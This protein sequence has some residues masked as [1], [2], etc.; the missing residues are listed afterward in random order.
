MNPRAHEENATSPCYFS[1]ENGHRFAAG[2]GRSGRSL[3]ADAICRAHGKKV[4]W[5]ILPVMLTKS[6]QHAGQG[7]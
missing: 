2:R 1:R 6:S 5:L 3:G 7:T 4:N